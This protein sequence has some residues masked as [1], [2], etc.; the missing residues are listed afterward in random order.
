MLRV[1]Y[2]NA[3]QAII[4][5]IILATMA[6]RW[7]PLGMRGHWMVWW[8]WK[9]CKPYVMAISVTRSQPNWTLMG[10]SGAAPEAPFSTT[11]N[12][13]PNYWISHGRMVSHPSNRVP[14]TCRIYSKDALK[15]FWLVVAQRP[16][17][18]LY[19]GVSFILAVTCISWS[20]LYV[21]Q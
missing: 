7:H 9:Q 19:V 12:K 8:A 10:D 18:I 1:M 14:D 11:I 2:K 17:K 15:L 21:L 4:L 6:I 20:N 16:D 5:P 3:G 13:T